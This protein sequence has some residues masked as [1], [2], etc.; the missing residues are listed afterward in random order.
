MA[1]N[2]ASAPLNQPIQQ[3]QSQA[4]SQTQQ[5]QQITTEKIQQV[6]GLEEALLSSNTGCQPQA[7]LMRW[8][9]IPAGY[10]LIVNPTLRVQHTSYCFDNW[11]GVI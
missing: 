1:Q 6:G 9:L 4:P 2:G 8:P 3:I 11:G 5:A 7:L 10:L